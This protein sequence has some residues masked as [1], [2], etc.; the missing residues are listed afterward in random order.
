[1]PDGAV[2]LTAPLK[3]DHPGAHNPDGKL[4][5]C[6]HVFNVTRRVVFRSEN[7]A[8]ARGHFLTTG[9]G[10]VDVC[11]FELRDLGRSTNDPWSTTNQK[12]RYGGMHWHHPM[13]PQNADGCSS[14]D[15]SP[16]GTG[17][18]RWGWTFHDAH[19]SSLTNSS[20]FN[21]A[22]S[23]VAFEMGNETG[24][25][26]DNVMICSVHGDVGLEGAR[27]TSDVGHTGAAL[28]CRSVDNSIRNVVVADSDIGFVYWP[29]G[30]YDVILPDG[31]HVSAMNLPVREFSGCECYGGRTQLVFNPWSV[32]TNEYNAYPDAKVSVVK[33]LTAWNFNGKLR[34]NYKT[35][36]ITYDGLIALGDAAGLPA[37]TNFSTGFYAGDYATYDD[38]LVNCELRGLRTGYAC[39]SMGN[40]TIQDSVF[41]C[42]QNVVVTPM[43]WNGSADQ[44]PPR[45]LTLRNVRHSLLAGNPNGAADVSAAVLM[46]GA[47][48]GPCNTL[49]T[50]DSVYV[51]QHNG[52]P[53]ANFRVYYGEQQPE[54]PLPQTH[55]KADGT[56]DLWA[57]PEAGLTNQQ[58]W[59]KYKVAFGGAVA[60]A[61]AKQIPGIVGL[62]D[63]VAVVVE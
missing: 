42:Y 46:W 20:V 13:M 50:P 40:Q 44:L 7:P 26:L 43:Y 38:K 58:S 9:D 22:G 18:I 61:S 5:F 51:Y 10:M 12:G 1:M 14:W 8:G 31:T 62:A 37:N 24:N 57:C 35:N 34:Y 23:G 32:G 6:P 11:H 53:A 59:D 60:P 36:R 21:F 39:G 33:N 48:Q 41:E 16:P 56:V 2:R 4:R 3:Y 29:E 25:T 49:V 27:G 47:M 45:T 52:D 15:T 55:V 19:D 54:F 28:W 30:L 63:P 17:K